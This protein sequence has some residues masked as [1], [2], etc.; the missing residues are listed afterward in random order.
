M[1]SSLPGVNSDDRPLENGTSITS[2]EDLSLPEVCAR[3]HGKVEA[4]LNGESKSERVRAAQAQTRRSLNVIG[5]ALRKYRYAGAYLITTNVAA[6][7][8]CKIES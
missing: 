1:P 6:G 8:N 7:E 5:E 4:F 3:I 2:E